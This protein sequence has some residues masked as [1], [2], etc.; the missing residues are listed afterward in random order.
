MVLSNPYIH[1]HV[2]H[3]HG[4]MKEALGEAVR[5]HPAKW[6]LRHRVKLPLYPSSA[7]APGAGLSTTSTGL[8]LTFCL[9]EGNFSGD[10]SILAANDVSNDPVMAAQCQHPPGGECVIRLQFITCLLLQIP[11]VQGTHL[12][13]SSV[14]EKATSC[15]STA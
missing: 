5:Y 10:N 6:L 13:G 7:P 1:N 2:E 14:M 3:T 4:Q 8:P 12:D 15:K 11:S 9:G